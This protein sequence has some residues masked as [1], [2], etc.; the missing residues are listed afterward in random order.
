[1]IKVHHINWQNCLS[2]S[3]FKQIYKGWSDD[4]NQ[5]THFFWGLGSTNIEEIEAVNKK[6][7]Q[8]YIIDV[9]YLTKDIVRYPRPS[10]A[11]PATT[12]FR[13]SKGGLHNCTL[14]V[15]ANPARFEKLL[16]RGIEWA[17]AINNYKEVPVEKGHIL[18]CPSS[19]GVCRFM[20]NC[21]Q[22]DWINHAIKM[23]KANTDRMVVLRNKPRPDNQWWGTNIKDSLKGASALVTNMSMA[24]IEAASIGVP[25]IVSP[26]HVMSE[27][28][29][30]NFNMINKLKPI[31][32][33]TL[34]EWGIK[35]ANC[36]F[37][38][39]EIREGV[40]YEYLS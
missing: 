20:H 40:A 31:K 11:D 35:A 2:H 4:P 8:Y 34:L 30:T 37:T 14:S 19:E 13:I 7:E 27:L 36:Q 25:S 39:K 32:K 15:G 5:V 21:S 10:I 28:A 12:Y 1:V 3:L 18:L 33:K 29:E 9:G 6:G 16:D 23:I 26:K 24:S 38:L 17:H 22:R